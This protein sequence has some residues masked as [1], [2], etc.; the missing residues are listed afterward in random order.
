MHRVTYGVRDDAKRHLPRAWAAPEGNGYSV[1][2]SKSQTVAV[3]PGGGA[4]ISAQLIRVFVIR[5]ND[6]Y[7]C[8]RSVKL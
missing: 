5:V 8:K 4:E 2:R 7:Y 3:C 6:F 1:E